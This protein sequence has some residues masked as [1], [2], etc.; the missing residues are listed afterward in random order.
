MR[1]V[2]YLKQRKEWDDIW[3]VVHP[4]KTINFHSITENGTIRLNWAP[5]NLQVVHFD[6]N[7]LGFHLLQAPDYPVSLTDPQ[8]LADGFPAPDAIKADHQKVMV[9]LKV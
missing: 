9:L 1:T 2:R 4:R 6:F 3:F 7:T 8:P 5:N